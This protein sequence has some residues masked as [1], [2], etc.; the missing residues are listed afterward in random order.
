MISLFTFLVR[1]VIRFGN[2]I[3]DSQSAQLRFTDM[4]RGQCL[5]ARYL[6]FVRRAVAVC[7]Y[8]WN[9]SLSGG[10]FSFLPLFFSLIAKCE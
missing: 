6:G 7:I 5:S 9:G 1:F 2:R 4:D 10:I 8:L 3:S